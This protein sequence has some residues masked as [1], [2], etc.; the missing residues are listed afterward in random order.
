MDLLTSERRSW[1]MS[2]IKG[3]NTVPEQELRSILHRIGFRFRLDTGAK[4]FGKPDIVLPKFLTVVFMHGCFWHRH[5]G[6]KQCYTPKTRV[7]FWK[8]KF[9]ANE[10]RDRKVV[11][12]LR[13]AGWCVIIV[14]ECE[15]KDT[16]G[17]EKRLLGIRSTHEKRNT[18][19]T[20]SE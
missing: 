9:I 7:D 11:R 2:K 15:L 17:L 13:R 5:F 10:E 18:S 14:W 16:C 6:C 20:K 12:T 19:R 1:N 4:M 8:R 3:R